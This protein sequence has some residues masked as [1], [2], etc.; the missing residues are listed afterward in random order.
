MKLSE[1]V[2]ALEVMGVNSVG[3]LIG[4]KILGSLLIFPI[5]I[6]YSMFFGFLGGGLVCY[7]TEIIPVNQYIL[8]IRS[9]S[10]DNFVFIRYALTKTIV[11]AFLIT[12]ISS[13]FGTC[14]DQ[15]DIVLVATG[16]ISQNGDDA[17]EL[18]NNGAVID[19]QI[20]K[21]T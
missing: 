17:I 7:F 9:F 18:Y 2:D 12:S 13:Y 3:Y 5:V 1:Q 15:F 4:P 14:F 19:I 20:P 16:S 21:N 6:I 10:E 11:F 8:G